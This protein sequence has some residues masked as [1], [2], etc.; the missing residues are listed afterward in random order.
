MLFELALSTVIPGHILV[1]ITT[2]KLPWVR[3]TAYKAGQ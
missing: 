1:F 3:I 2:L